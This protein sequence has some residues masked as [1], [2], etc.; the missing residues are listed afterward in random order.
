MLVDEL[1]HPRPEGCTLSCE[2]GPFWTTDAPLVPSGSVIAKKS[3]EGEPLFFSAT[4]KN[5]KGEGIEGVIAEVVRSF[6]LRFHSNCSFAC[7]ASSCFPVCSG[8]QTAK[9]RTT[10]RTQREMERTIGDGS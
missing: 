2:P 6:L 9:A 4:V 7:G 1:E 3:T 8:K 10:C 5:T